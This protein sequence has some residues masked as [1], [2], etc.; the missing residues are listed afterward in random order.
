MWL[1]YFDIFKWHHGEKDQEEFEEQVILSIPF[2]LP[3]K[4]GVGTL[5]FSYPHFT[6][7]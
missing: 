3:K 6:F 2:S 7:N 1:K 5:Q 4:T